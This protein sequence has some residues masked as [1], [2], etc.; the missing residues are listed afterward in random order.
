[1]DGLSIERVK[2]LHPAIRESAQAV[3]SACGSAKISM[4]ITQ[5]YR[6]FDEQDQLYAQSRTM[7]GENVT[8]ARGG[9]SWHNYGLAFDFC[10]MDDNGNPY[11]DEKCDDWKNVVAIAKTNGFEWGGDW[12]FTDYPHF[13]NRFGLTINDAYKIYTD[14]NVD[15]NGYINIR[16]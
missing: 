8:N 15:S 14:G 12:K 6:T 16:T 7:P 3:L 11:W 9:Q 2:L 10:L 5:G 1:M 4:R 13:Q